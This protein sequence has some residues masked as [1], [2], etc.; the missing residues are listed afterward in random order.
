MS[1]ADDYDPELLTLLQNYHFPGNVRELNTMVLDAVSTHRGRMLSPK[2]FK[3]IKDTT[4]SFANKKIQP[5]FD[6]Q[7]SWASQL[8]PLPKLQEAANTLIRE[9]LS[10]AN[11][12]QQVAAIML[13]ITPQALSKRLKRLGK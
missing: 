11:N 8:E 9:A 3:V 2:A 1:F 6:E 13:G 10:R 4:E 12:N 5:V 7:L